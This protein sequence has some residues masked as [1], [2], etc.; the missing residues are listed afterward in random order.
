MGLV[1]DILSWACLIGG[2]FFTITGALGIVRLPDFWARL[3]ASGVAESG[4]M[5]LII[6]GL[7]LQAGW[8]L[9]TVKLI[10][11]GIFLFIT[12]PTSTH[13]IA[14]AAL[15]TGWRPKPGTGIEQKDTPPFYDVKEPTVRN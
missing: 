3:H 8:G 5:I 14:N 10:I 2:S 15:V 12:G 9:V 4:G 1:A 6:L 11:I 7:C 13:A